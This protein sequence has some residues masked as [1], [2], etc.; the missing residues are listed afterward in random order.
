MVIVTTIIVINVTFV[1]TTIT[2]CV[3]VAVRVADIDI[4]SKRETTNGHRIDS[5]NHEDENDAENNDDR[6]ASQHDPTY[7]SGH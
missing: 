5:N 6:D 2:T 3:T 7:E 4:P 1:A